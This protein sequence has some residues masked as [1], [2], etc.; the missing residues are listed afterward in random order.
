MRI[1]E[2]IGSDR[3]YVSSWDKKKSTETIRGTGG[4][5]IGFKAVNVS[6]QNK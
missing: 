1:T 5:S 3:R 2:Q 6:K 4:M